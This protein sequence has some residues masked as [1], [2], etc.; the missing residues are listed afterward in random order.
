MWNLDLSSTSTES[1]SQQAPIRY[2]DTGE[3]RFSCWTYPAIVLNMYK[4]RDNS[5]FSSHSIIWYSRIYELYRLLNWDLCLPKNAHLLMKSH[6]S[7]LLS[8]HVH[9][10]QSSLVLLSCSGPIAD[11]SSIRK[12]ISHVSTQKI[13]GSFQAET[14]SQLKNNNKVS[15]VPLKWLLMAM[16]LK[17]LNA[18]RRGGSNSPLLLLFDIEQKV[19]KVIPP[20]AGAETTSSH[21]DKASG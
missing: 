7:S 16:Q 6:Y 19:G 18:H 14:S 17:L 12:K 5:V 11:A 13:W 3:Y 20:H 4:P 21:T 15:A 1:L 2:N 9:C 10:E 8:P